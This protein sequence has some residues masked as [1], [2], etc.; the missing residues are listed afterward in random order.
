MTDAELAER[1]NEFFYQ[2]NREGIS[3]THI[4][5]ATLYV[6][7]AQAMVKKG[8]SERDFVRRQLHEALDLILSSVFEAQDGSLPPAS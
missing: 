6:L 7:C 1:L 4:A 8:R 5:D 2:L 3:P